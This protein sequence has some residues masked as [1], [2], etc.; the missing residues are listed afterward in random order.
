MFQL[1]NLQ[2]GRD[3]HNLWTT[4][5]RIYHNNTNNNLYILLLLDTENKFNKHNYVYSPCCN[6]RNSALENN[7]SKA[8]LWNTRDIIYLF[9]GKMD[10]NVQN[11]RNC[12]KRTRKYEMLLMKSNGLQNVVLCRYWNTSV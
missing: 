5:S 12:S 11:M 10:E 3:G 1:V 6:D 2:I 9:S 7:E 4:Y 8:I